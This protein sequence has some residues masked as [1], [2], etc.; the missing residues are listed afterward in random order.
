MLVKVFQSTPSTTPARK[1]L[2]MKATLFAIASHFA[3]VSAASAAGPEGPSKVILY[4]IVFLAF[5]VFLLGV[6]AAPPLSE[7]L[8]RVKAFKEEGASRTR[9]SGPLHGNA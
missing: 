5:G 9:Q 2:T 1:D 6:L 7:A 8:K 4:P 3:L